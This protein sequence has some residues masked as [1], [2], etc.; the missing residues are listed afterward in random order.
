MWKPGMSV[1]LRSSFAAPRSASAASSAIFSGNRKLPAMTASNSTTTSVSSVLNSVRIM[2]RLPIIP[3]WNGVTHR[4]LTP[5]ALRRTAYTIARRRSVRRD[6]LPGP[7]QGERHQVTVIVEAVEV[8]LIV[9]V[10]VL[11]QQVP[12]GAEE[13]SRANAELRQVFDTPFFLRYAVVQETIGIAVAAVSIARAP[14]ERRAISQRM[15]H[16][17]AERMT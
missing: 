6:R 7:F 5:R 16:A 11:E 10:L 9:V 2:R 4:P 17:D 8:R 14:F 12:G 3:K 1:S 15:P 13:K